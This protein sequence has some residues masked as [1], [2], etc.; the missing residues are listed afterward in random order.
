MTSSRSPPVHNKQLC[1]SPN[2]SLKLA[3]FCVQPLECV[4]VRNVFSVPWDTRGVRWPP[5]A[6]TCGW[7]SLCQSLEGGKH[8][9]RA[10]RATVTLSASGA[11]EANP[12]HLLLS[13]ARGQGLLAPG[14]RGGSWPEP[15][16][17]ATA[18]GA[19]LTPAAAGRGCIALH[20][21]L[22]FE[23]DCR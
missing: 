1:F 15:P 8:A 19:R 7:G 18:P 13:V 16:P 6:P 10:P 21:L 9:P 20:T 12:G 3:A 11:D 23:W 4:A 5:S 2:L 14:A 17:E 22:G